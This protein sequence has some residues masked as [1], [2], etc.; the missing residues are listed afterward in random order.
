MGVI[1]RV[2][3]GVIVNGAVP[4]ADEGT[5]DSIMPGW[6]QNSNARRPSAVA[7]FDGDGQSDLPDGIRGRLTPIPGETPAKKTLTA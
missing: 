3:V 4:A 6:W 5:H 2:T 7:R 1:V